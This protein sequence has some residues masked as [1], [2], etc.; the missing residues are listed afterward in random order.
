MYHVCPKV[1]ACRLH[2]F[3]SFFAYSFIHSLV[4]SLAWH[5]LTGYSFYAESYSK[6]RETRLEKHSLDIDM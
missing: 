1:L 3:F 4:H 2:V 6:T 5:L